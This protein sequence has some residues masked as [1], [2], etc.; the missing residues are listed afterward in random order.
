VEVTKRQPPAQAQPI[1]YPDLE[2][3]D[4]PINVPLPT[5]EHL[6]SQ[7][8]LE[9]YMTNLCQVVWS[10]AFYYYSTNQLSFENTKIYSSQQILQNLAR[11][12]E[13]YNL[14]AKDFRVIDNHLEGN[15]LEYMLSKYPM[16][17]CQ[18]VSRNL[19]NSIREIDDTD[20]I[21]NN[22]LYKSNVVFKLR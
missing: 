17:L 9:R 12:C 14:Q 13:K 5:D 4:R 20:N 16:T 2:P 21:A 19:N 22:F 10:R 7:E 18:E 6:L 15:V 1:D 8:C 11:L 3:R